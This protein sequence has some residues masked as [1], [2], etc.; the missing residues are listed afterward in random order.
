MNQPVPNG[1]SDKNARINDALTTK[2][3]FEKWTVMQI[4]GVAKTLKKQR[5]TVMSELIKLK[6]TLGE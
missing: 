2:K 6:G 3:S 1:A 5:P 4:N